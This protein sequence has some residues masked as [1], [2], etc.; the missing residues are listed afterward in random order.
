[1]CLIIEK[2]FAYKSSSSLGKACALKAISQLVNVL[3]LEVQREP[4]IFH[5]I[6]GY[7]HNHG[8]VV[9]N[10]VFIQII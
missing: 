10:F 9:Y 8:G 4:V 2:T 1:M 3:D 6:F 7:L 5:T